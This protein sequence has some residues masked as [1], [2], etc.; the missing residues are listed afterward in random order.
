MSN[1]RLQ[2][3]LRMAFVIAVGGWEQQGRVG[4]RWPI[5]I[6]QL[7]TPAFER[8]HIHA[9]IL[10]VTKAR[11]IAVCASALVCACVN[12]PHGLTSK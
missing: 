10:V 12:S 8:L 7:F 2:L 9:H 11:S 4:K 1:T 6:V 3:K 5:R